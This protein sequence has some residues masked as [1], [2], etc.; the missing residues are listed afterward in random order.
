MK[1][2]LELT[3]PCGLDCFNCDFYL[4]TR[5]DPDAKKRIVEMSQQHNMPIEILRCEG[6]RAHDGKIPLQKHVFGE[7]HFCAA[8]EC[9]QSKGVDL[10]CDCDDFPC[11][12]LHP[13]ADRADALPHN[14]KVFNL[15][16]IE[17]MGLDKWAA[18]K[19]ADVRRDYFHKLWDLKS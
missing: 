11:D 17:K 3:A 19:A 18:T 2:A 4:V 16:L 7:D 15:C 13:Y 8:Y 6:C 14:T 5:D 12:H 10:C 1:D 9:S